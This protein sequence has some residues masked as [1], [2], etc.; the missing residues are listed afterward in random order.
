MI[1]HVNASCTALALFLLACNPVL[2]QSDDAAFYKGKQITMIIGGGVGGGFDVYARAAAQFMPKHIAGNP[3]IVPKNLP[4]GFGVAAAN[5]LSNTVEKDGLTFA[6]FT[7]AAAFEP[8]LGTANAKYEPE[9]FGWLGS[10][11]KLQNVC[12]T[13]HQNDAKTLEDLRRKEVM[14]GASGATGDTALLPNILNEMLGT[15]LRVVNGYEPGMGIVMAVERGEIAGVCG[16][17]WSTIKASKPDWV[18]DKKLNVILQLGLSKVSELPDV[19][20][21]I[22]LVKDP[23]D[24]AVLQLILVRQE[25]GRPFAAPHGILP[26]RLAILQAAFERTM[27]DPEFVAYAEKLQLEIDVLTGE[28]VRKLLVQAYASPPNVVA[29]ARKLLQPSQ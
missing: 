17:A 26:H 9:K 7:Q 16:L 23:T 18:R 4:A 13:W 29:K 3:T 5:A 19:P 25:M 12:T 1:K 6:A 2:A 22:D 28:E 8:L 21:A 10:M 27:K 24:K 11:G 15:R 20:M 14:V